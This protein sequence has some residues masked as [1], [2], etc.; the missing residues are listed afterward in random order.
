AADVDDVGKLRID[1]DRKS[2][3]LAIRPRQLRPRSATVGRLQQA[4]YVRSCVDDLRIR[5]IDGE[6]ADLRR[7]EA[8]V[9]CSPSDT[10]IGRSI[11]AVLSAAAAAARLNPRV[12]GVRRGRCE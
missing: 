12:N 6:R 9:R 2:T 5:G 4:V 3:R 1:R 11:D 10:T 8:G 7:R